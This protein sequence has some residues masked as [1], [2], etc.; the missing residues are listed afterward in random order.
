ML[1][2]DSPTSTLPATVR[3]D[4]CDIVSSPRDAF[5]LSEVSQPEGPNDSYGMRELSLLVP[6]T[7]VILVDGTGERVRRVCP[8]D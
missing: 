4:P 5:D 1:C 6:D 8:G 3:V 2:P 7:T